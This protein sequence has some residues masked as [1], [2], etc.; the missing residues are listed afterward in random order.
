MRRPWESLPENEGIWPEEH[1]E[2]RPI[3]D[4]EAMDAI[5]LG[6]M[7]RKFARDVTIRRRPASRFTQM[8]GGRRGNSFSIHFDRGTVQR[9]LNHGTRLGTEPF[10]MTRRKLK[11]F[12]NVADAEAFATQQGW[13]IRSSNPSNMRFNARTGMARRELRQRYEFSKDT[14]MAK[15][16]GKPTV[17]PADPYQHGRGSSASAVVTP[18]APCEE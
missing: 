15:D 12:E 14:Y 3:R 1:I 16:S 2:A 18:C 13:K 10:Q 9:D 17:F 6:E 11:N 4:G 5:G 8:Y 7:F